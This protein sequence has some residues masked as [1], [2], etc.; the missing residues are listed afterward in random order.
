MK[1]EEKKTS[2]GIPMAIIVIALV[3]VVAAGYY[4]YNSA[5]TTPARNTNQPGSNQS[6][7]R[8][9]QIPPNA[10]PGAPISHNLLGSP[11]ASVT[12]EEFADFQCGSCAAV[13]PIMK[14]VQSQYGS[15]IRFIF[16][17]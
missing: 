12:V 8:G 3:G 10:P 13:H 4:F 5:K 17:N 15:K 6:A 16:R 1:K 2:G 11:S 9:A 7:P 14:E